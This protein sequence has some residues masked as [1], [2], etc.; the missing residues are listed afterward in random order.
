MDDE[1]KKQAKARVKL[2][3]EAPI[4]FHEL[5]DKNLFDEAL[6]YQKEVQEIL[7]VPLKLPTREPGWYSSRG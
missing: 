7:S 6:A 1:Y 2:S 4:K 3:R 5:M